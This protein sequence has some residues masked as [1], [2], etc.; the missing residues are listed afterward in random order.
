[1]RTHAW[2][3]VPLFL[4]LGPAPVAEDATVPVTV[5]GQVVDAACYMI[6]P[7]AAAG[8]SHDECGRACVQRGVP[9]G[10]VDE[11]RKELYLGDAASSKALLP[12]LHHRVRVTGQSAKRSEPLQLEMPVGETHT[13]SV[14]VEGGYNALSV[15]RVERAR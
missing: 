14:R 4:S 9:L 6:H 2:L 5:V 15:D 10:I 1:M 13:M 8:V 7:Q 3:I 12:Y 11:T